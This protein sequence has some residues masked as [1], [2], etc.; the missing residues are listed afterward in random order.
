MQADEKSTASYTEGWSEC[1]N[2]SFALKRE[3]H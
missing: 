3:T 2:D 1:Y